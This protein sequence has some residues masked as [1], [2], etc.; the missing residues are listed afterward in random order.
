MYFLLGSTAWIVSIALNVIFWL[1]IFVSG[2]TFNALAIRY[3]DLFFFIQH[4]N[5]NVDNKISI[6]FFIIDT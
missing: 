3:N 4:R 6:I 1:A 2:S 5:F